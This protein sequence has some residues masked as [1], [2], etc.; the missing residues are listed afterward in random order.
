M[1]QCFLHSRW[2]SHRDQQHYEAAV[3]YQTGFSTH[4]STADGL[5]DGRKLST[6]S[7]QPVRLCSPPGHRSGASMPH[8]RRW[9]SEPQDVPVRNHQCSRHCFNWV[10]LSAI[11]DWRICA[12][13]GNLISCTALGRTRTNTHTLVPPS[14]TRER[15]RK[16]F[17]PV[18]IRLLNTDTLTNWLSIYPGFHC[19]SFN[20]FSCSHM[21]FSRFWFVSKQSVVLSVCP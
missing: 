7:R 1:H 20:T 11:S 18:V 8:L 21:T 5:M 19:L 6:H 4:I 17:L 3:L 9:L 14:R 12:A 16:S 2:Q 15:H 13:E 10:L